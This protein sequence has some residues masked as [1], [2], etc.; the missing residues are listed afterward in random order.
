[1]AHAGGDINAILFDLH[2][3]SPAVAKLPSVE[4]LIDEIRIDN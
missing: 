4:L 3:T 1:V 2:A